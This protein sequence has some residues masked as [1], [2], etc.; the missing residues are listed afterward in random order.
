MAMNQGI[1]SR[2]L[3]H[4]PV[5][6]GDGSHSTN[7]GYVS[8]LGNKVGSHTRQGD[9]GY[10]G[11]VFHTGKSFQPTPFGN[12]IAART[13]CGPGGSRTVYASGSQG[14]QGDVAGSRAPQGRDILNN[15]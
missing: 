6:T 11:E 2:N 10:R 12:E 5:K 9:T 13:T 14:Q 7:L 1:K 4:P 3:V 15:E 8:Q